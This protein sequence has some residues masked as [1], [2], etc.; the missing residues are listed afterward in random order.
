[1][2][3]VP[4]PIARSRPAADPAAAEVS[5]PP[6]PGAARA[7]R[8]WLGVLISAGFL[9][10]A[11]RGQHLGEVWA[12]LRSFDLRWLPPALLL[13][14]AGVWVR[15]VR[16][17]VL[18]RPL[19][20]VPARAVFPVVVAGYT[21]NNV[22]PLRTGELVRA[23]LLG[24]R[25]GVRKTAALATIAVERLFDGLTMLA[26]MLAATTAISFTAELRRLALVA[27]LLFA[28]VLLGLVALTLGGN[29]RDRLL[30]LVLGPLP[31]PLADRIERVAESFLGGLG[32]LTRKVDLALV[33]GTSLVAWGFEASMYWTI[34]RGF[35]A[36]LADAIGPA[37][38]L[39]TT[40]VANLW[41]LVP[42]APGYVGTF[43][44]GVRIALHDALGVPSGPTLS[45]ALLVHA[46]LWFPITLWGAVIWWRQHLSLSQANDP[47]ALAVDGVPDAP[48]PHALAGPPPVSEAGRPVEREREALRR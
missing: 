27:F 18:L 30:Q 10:Y 40:G 20:A 46:A 38:A 19:V 47:G 32:V 45:Y 33:A 9:F 23:F 25:H 29:V 21:A 22:L 31:T 28:A 35:D 48:P 13:Y 16:W 11:F 2:R 42:A 34:A 26:F 17:S 37:A 7:W 44:T 24:R 3:T 43:E 14:F 41:T 8:A 15:A 4:A 6:R 12:T 1:A 5:Q 39:L 36:S